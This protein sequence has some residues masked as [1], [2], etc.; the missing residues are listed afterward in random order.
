MLKRTWSPTLGGFSQSFRKYIIVFL[1]LAWAYVITPPSIRSCDLIGLFGAS[2]VTTPAKD[3]NEIFQT[4][5]KTQNQGE[6]EK[7]VGQY[8][9]T[10]RFAKSES[11]T[12]MANKPST[13]FSISVSNWTFPGGKCFIRMALK[14]IFAELA[15]GSEM[16]V[17]STSSP[18][19]ISRVWNERENVC[20]TLS[21]H[22]T[23]DCWTYG[24]QHFG[25]VEK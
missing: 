10:N 2:L 5:K 17:N 14:R 15:L 3:R 18:T 25:K 22:V 20:S 4:N 6:Q 19:H 8:P 13:F 16:V 9:F 11:V 7:G 24:V 21:L 1:L 12:K 23:A